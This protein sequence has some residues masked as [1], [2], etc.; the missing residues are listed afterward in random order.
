MR[1][2]SCLAKRF[3][4]GVGCFAATLLTASAAVI[5]TDTT[6]AP[7]DTSFEGADIIVSNATLTVDGPH[8]FSSLTILSN[9]VLT[10]TFSTNGILAH[11]LAISN[12]EHF[13]TGTTVIPLRGSN[14]FTA[15]VVVA[16]PSTTYITNADYWL[17]DLGAG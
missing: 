16:N 1:M 5:S 14:I 7:G 11:V 10:H 8:T 6:I 2:F 13:L 12:E 17:I 9:G 3:S 4:A 15:S